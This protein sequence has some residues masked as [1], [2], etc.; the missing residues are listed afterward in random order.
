MHIH[1]SAFP[2]GAYTH[3]FGMETY[4]QKEKVFN[5]ETLLTYCRTYLHEN[6]GFGDGIFVKEAWQSLAHSSSLLDLYELDSFCHAQKLANESRQGSIK[7]GRQFLE[8]VEPLCSS[9]LLTEW[10]KAVKEQKAYGHHAISYGIYAYTQG[11]SLDVALSSFLYSSIASLIHNAV[12]AVPLGQT[13]G[14]HAIK[15]ILSDCEQVAALIID[16]TLDDV[17]NQ[18]IGIELASMEHECLFS[19]LFIS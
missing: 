9:A 4:I 1:D 7:M 12:R 15:E 10:K 18:A 3:S 11:L 17:S 6:I 13:T 14:V 5:K 8:T 16:R 19:R 2:I